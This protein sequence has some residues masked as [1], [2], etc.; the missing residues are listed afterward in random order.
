MIPQPQ[1]SYL[2]TTLKQTCRLSHQVML[3]FSTKL[4]LNPADLTEQYV[5]GLREAGFDDNQIVAIV[6]VT[7]LFNFMNCIAN[8]M[9]V[10]VPRPFTCSVGPF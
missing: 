9:G 7:C 6:L 1:T 2:P 8:S 3:D 5:E 10:A 4:A